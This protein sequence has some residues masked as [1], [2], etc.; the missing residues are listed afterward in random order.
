MISEWSS[1][2]ALRMDKYL[3]L[4]RLYVSAAFGYLSN[5]QWKLDL[6]TDYLSLMERMPLSFDSKKV[7]DGLRYHI[8]DVWID[9]LEPIDIQRADVGDLL[10]PIKTLE[11]AGRTKII[12][13]RARE[14]LT[15]KRLEAW[16]GTIDDQ[17]SSGE[18]WDGFR[19]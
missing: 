11:K 9:E 16:Q 1:I 6:V 2:P 10:K 3:R 8:L 7:P 14:V 18:E 5:H 15:D 13:T 17:S 4:V 12:R 19:D